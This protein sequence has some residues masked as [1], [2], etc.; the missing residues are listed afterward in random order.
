MQMVPVVKQH[1][2][3][4]VSEVRVLDM[5]YYQNI[6]I[7]RVARGSHVRYKVIIVLQGNDALSGLKWALYS[8]SLV[9]LK[10]SYKILIYLQL[11]W[12]IVDNNS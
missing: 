2:D 6:G 8:R 10:L 7:S 4:G 1:V 5:S 11:T 3:I 9:L 12:Q